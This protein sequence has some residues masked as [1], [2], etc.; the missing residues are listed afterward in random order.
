MP[1]A[2]LFQRARA[3]QLH[4][5]E[6]IA[7]EVTRMLGDARVSGKFV[8]FHEQLWQFGRYA[9]IAPDSATYKNL[10]DKFVDRLLSASD[11]FLGEVID[12]NGG[13]EELLTAPY[14]FADSKLA[15]IYGK[16]ATGDTPA[17]ID[18]DKGEREGFL[19]QAGFLA[20]NA[21]A[22]KTDPIHR[23]LFILRDVLCR[24]IPDPPPGAATTPP[25]PATTPIV[26]TRDEVSLLTGQQYCPTC[27]GQINEPGFSFEGFDA[28]GRARTQDNGQ[29]V[30]TT[31]S[32]IV[33][34]DEVQFQDASDLV[35]ALAQSD[36]AR[37]CYVA[38]WLEF[39]NGREFATVDVALR[40]RLAKQG[41]G[42]KELVTTL[43]TSP[44]FRSRVEAGE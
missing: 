25:P 28:V 5:D 6:Q 32:I 42:V 38:R 26:T 39:A 43:A 31:G 16:S 29:N 14:A 2:Q 3:G 33:D 15:P 41:M 9:K 19:M 7:G 30:D 44:E 18:F 35:E 27:H 11:A 21:Y 4:T 23:G 13:L 36:E 34:G 22:I 37:N 8:S 20:S 1:D 10:P 17:R 12:N 40:D 24:A